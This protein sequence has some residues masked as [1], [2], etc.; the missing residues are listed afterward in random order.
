MFWRLLFWR[1]FTRA[2]NPVSNPVTHDVCMW[3]VYMGYL[4]AATRPISPS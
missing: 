2:A 3:L 4:G 1:H